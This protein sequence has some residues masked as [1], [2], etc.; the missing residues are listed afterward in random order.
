MAVGDFSEI[1]LHLALPN[2][3]STTAGFDSSR[4][5]M[6]EDPPLAGYLIL[7]DYTGRLFRTANC[8][9]PWWL[10]DQRR[11]LGFLPFSFCLGGRRQHAESW[12]ARLEKLTRGGPPMAGSADSSPP[13]GGDWENS[14]RTSARSDPTARS[15][16][17]DRTRQPARYKAQY[18]P[19]DSCV[20]RQ[21]I[22][23]EP[24]SRSLIL[25]APS[26]ARGHSSKDGRSRSY[27]DLR[28]RS[29]IG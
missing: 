18:T 14:P 7:V 24:S 9:L 4:E 27:L 1:E 26:R 13:A 20:L 23:A 11:R 12:H 21:I 28:M 6:L 25:A 8:F 22:R 17:S 10:M 16:P 5:G 3:R 2:P 15:D 19:S 29:I